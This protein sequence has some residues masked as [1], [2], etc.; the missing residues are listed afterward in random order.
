MAPRGGTPRRAHARAPMTLVRHPRPTSTDPRADAAPRRTPMSSSGHCG[1]STSRAPTDVNNDAAPIRSA[2][3]TSAPMPLAG[4]PPHRATR[5][6][7]APTRDDDDA[8]RAARRDEHLTRRS[9]AVRIADPRGPMHA[10]PCSRHSGPWA[11][12]PTRHERR[13]TRRAPTWVA[14]RRSR[15]CCARRFDRRPLSVTRLPLPRCCESC[16]RR[17]L[18]RGGPGAFAFVGS[19]SAGASVVGFELGSARGVGDRVGVVVHVV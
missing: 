5:D 3:A 2:R 16:G 18:T 4:A 10:A 19:A 9:T 15:S 11:F 6:L 1:Q 17:G 7:R 14:I 13:S 12:D 8:A